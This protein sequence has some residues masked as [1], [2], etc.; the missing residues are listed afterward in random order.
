[1][2]DS[3]D[4]P[5]HNDEGSLP[6]TP[7]AQSRAAY[8]EDMLPGVIANDERETRVGA[9][10]KRRRSGIPLTS[11]EVYRDLKAV[12]SQLMVSFMQYDKGFSTFLRT[13]SHAL[14]YAERVAAYAMKDYPRDFE[15]D[16]DIAGV[17]D[18][19]NNIHVIGYAWRK[20][21]DKTDGKALVVTVNKIATEALDR[22][23]PSVNSAIA[24]IDI[25]ADKSA[26]EMSKRDTV[27]VKDDIKGVETT[28]IDKIDTEASPTEAHKTDKVK[29]S[30]IDAANAAL[31]AKIDME[32]AAIALETIK[33]DVAA[34]RSDTETDKTDK[35]RKK[36]VEIA[37]AHEIAVPAKID[38]KAGK[39]DTESAKIE[40]SQNDIESTKTDLG[41]GKS[42]TETNKADSESN[43]SDTETVKNDPQDD[44]DLSW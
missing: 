2:S 30:D 24:D 27:A 19:L 17:W 29:N 40:A 3:R 36:D 25:E 1:M 6:T 43:K 4:T 21:R 11:E 22:I 16:K 18:A 12:L 34:A 39:S 31:V 37:K 26:I 44:I 9:A 7:N 20:G 23:Y 42:D 35:I 10:N 32:A 38:V 41:A 15:A 5:P 28:R 13:P 14:D 8:F 33:P